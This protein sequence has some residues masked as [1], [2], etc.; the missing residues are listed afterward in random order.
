MADLKT[1]Y[2]QVKKV[3]VLTPE[4]TDIF[5]KVW[6]AKT[7]Q[8]SRVTN[9]PVSSDDCLTHFDSALFIKVSLR[10]SWITTMSFIS[11][12]D[13]RTMVVVAPII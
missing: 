2:D 6:E 10:K 11:S 3:S 12:M 1:D 5:R 13:L 4:M 9:N 7:S 8:S